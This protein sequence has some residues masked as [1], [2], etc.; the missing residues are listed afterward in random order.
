MDEFTLKI[1]KQSKITFK[2]KEKPSEE[3]K[4]NENIIYNSNENVSDQLFNIE[5][6]LPLLEPEVSIISKPSTSL[7][8]KNDKSDEEDNSTPGFQDDLNTIKK[9]LN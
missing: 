1:K 9:R 5:D 3:I 7:N 8:I 6:N 4:E 2:I